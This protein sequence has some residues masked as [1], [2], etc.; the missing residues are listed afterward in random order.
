MLNWSVVCT[1]MI[2]HETI[3]LIIQLQDILMYNNCAFV[4]YF[5]YHIKQNPKH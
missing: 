5:K 3:V 2:V 4:F 1:F